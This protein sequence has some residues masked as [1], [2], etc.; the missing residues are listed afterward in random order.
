V[1]LKSSD[2]VTAFLVTGL[3]QSV[4]PRGTPPPSGNELPSR[5]AT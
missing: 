1:K 2:T 3:S 4:A 5:S